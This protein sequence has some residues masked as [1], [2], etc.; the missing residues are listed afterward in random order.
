[1]N[2]EQ[3]HYLVEISYT[4]SISQAAV[5]LHVSQAAISQAILSLEKE[6]E[7]PL[8]K[9]SRLGTIPTSEG[10]RIIAK[11]NVILQSIQD[12]QAEAKQERVE[13]TLRIAA[14]PSLF[15]SLLPSILPHFKQHYPNVVLQLQELGSDE[16]INGI[17]ERTI[18]VGLAVAIHSST[19]QQLPLH[20]GTMQVI[21]SAQSPLANMREV[22]V[23][24]LAHETIALFHGDRW[25][26]YLTQWRLDTNGPFTVLCTTN[27]SETI[28]RLVAANVAISFFTDVMLVND[29]YLAQGSIVAIPLVDYEPRELLFALYSDKMH[30]KQ[31][32]IKAFE[33]F[34]LQHALS[35]S[36]K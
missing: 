9:R 22:T 8:F 16:I 30:P 5:N 32:L 14:I 33:T 36:K 4:R 26:S 29:P 19:V 35:L 12:I 25:L 10:E 31:N 13:G 18:D 27:Q 20:T 3:M 11:A 6:L 23:K 15:T 34:V 24:E 7:L 17:E 2:L 28:K 21:V 1:M